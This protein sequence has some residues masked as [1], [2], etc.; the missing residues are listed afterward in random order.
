MAV[1]A[2]ELSSRELEAGVERIVLQLPMVMLTFSTL[3]TLCLALN[4]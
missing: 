1:A 2:T 3:G 4:F